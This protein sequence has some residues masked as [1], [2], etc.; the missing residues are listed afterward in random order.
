MDQ[1]NVISP[2]TSC[3]C[4]MKLANVPACGHQPCFNQQ[5]RQAAYQRVPADV[6]ADVT[7]FLHLPIQP[8]SMAS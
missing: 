7:L 2:Q 5:E 8:H 6:P 1:K 4:Q 3:R